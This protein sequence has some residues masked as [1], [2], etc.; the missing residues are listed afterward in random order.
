MLSALYWNSPSFSSP[1]S[2]SSLTRPSTDDP[3]N[4]FWLARTCVM[5]VSHDALLD[6]LLPC[7]APSQSPG[8]K[9]DIQFLQAIKLVHDLGHAIMW[10]S[11]CAKICA[12]RLGAC[13]AKL[14]TFGISSL[15]FLKTTRKFSEVASAD[16]ALG[17]PS[18][19]RS[20]WQPCNRNRQCL[21]HSDDTSASSGPY[22]MQ[23]GIGTRIGMG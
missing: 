7:K 5:P 16:L 4:A 1:P 19:L 6:S 10:A 13:R 18:L 21:G 22:C 12:T 23:S 17:V 2:P 20:L 3:N 15:P 14:P 8:C 9:N 11:I